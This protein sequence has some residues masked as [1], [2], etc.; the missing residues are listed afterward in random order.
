[1]KTLRTLGVSARTTVFRGLVAEEIIRAAGSGKYDLLVLG[2]PLGRKGSQIS[3]TGIVGEVLKQAGD[4][5]ILLVR[6]QFI[7]A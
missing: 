3:L 5:A 1:M 7:R 4:Q 2:V 6:S